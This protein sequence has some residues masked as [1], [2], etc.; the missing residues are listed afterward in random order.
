MPFFLMLYFRPL[1][2]IVSP[3]YFYSHNLMYKFGPFY[4]EL[5][6]FLQNIHQILF[7]LVYKFLFPQ[8]RCWNHCSNT[9]CCWNLFYQINKILL[10]WIIKFIVFP[11]TIFYF[12]FYKEWI[13]WSL[14]SSFCFSMFW[15]FVWTKAAMKHCTIVRCNE[16][17]TRNLAI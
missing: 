6:S 11:K 2:W 10:I 16:I 3:P 12:Y 14:F 17:L 9:G 13:N 4:F 15:R 8:V 7:Y 1:H 5:N